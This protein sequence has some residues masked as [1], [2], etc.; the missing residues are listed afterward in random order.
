[1]IDDEEEKLIDR[2]HEKDEIRRELDKHVA[3]YMAR[4]GKVTRYKFGEMT[5]D[6]NVQEVEFRTRMERSVKQ[7]D[8]EEAKSR[9]NLLKQIASGKPIDLFGEE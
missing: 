1:M 8:S 5:Q 7:R 4:G 2:R 9:E 6:I 3:E